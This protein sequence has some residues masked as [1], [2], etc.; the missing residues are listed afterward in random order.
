M[1]WLGVTVGS[2]GKLLGSRDEIGC[3]VRRCGVGML[4]DTLLRRR[5]GWFGHVERR[6]ERDALGRV[7]LVEAPG[8]R[9]PG[10]PKKT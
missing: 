1:C 9:P 3:R 7:R 5:L 6:D 2:S 4:G 8:R 10:R